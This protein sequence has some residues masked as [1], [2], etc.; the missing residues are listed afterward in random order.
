MMRHRFREGERVKARDTL[1]NVSPGT[2]GTITR[3][4]AVLWGLYEV[5]FDRLPTPHVVWEEDLSADAIAGLH[6]REM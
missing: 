6:D 5:Q 1:F 2:L 4:Y 3:C